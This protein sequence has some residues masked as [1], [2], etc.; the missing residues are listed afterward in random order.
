[1]PIISV[2]SPNPSNWTWFARDVAGGEN[3][4]FH[5]EEPRSSLERWVTRPRLSRI[6]GAFRCVRQ[7]NREKSEAFAAHSQFSTFWLSLARCAIRSDIPLLSFSFHFSALPTGFRLAISKWAFAQV[8]RFVVHSEPERERY[9]EHFGLDPARFELVRWGVEPSVT[10]IESAVTEVPGTYICALGKDGRDYGTLIQAMDRLPHL[11]L[12]VVA[13]PHNLSGLQIPENVKVFFNIS[14][15]RAM[16]ILKHC[17]F[18][19]LPLETAKTSCGHITI[20][21]AMFCGKAILATHSAGI[22]DYFPPDYDSAGVGPSDVDSW[23]RELSSMATDPE[24]RQACV[25]KG[26]RFA[27]EHCSHQAALRN[28]LAVFRNAGIVLDANG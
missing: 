2:F 20:V 19:A 3:W 17:L 23:V 8:S 18:M 11:T 25:Q 21:S 13:Q 6:F 16:N 27:S 9:A 15:E 10:E 1:M 12:V 24:R 7:A 4:A 28:T 22:A 26:L 14:P 5:N